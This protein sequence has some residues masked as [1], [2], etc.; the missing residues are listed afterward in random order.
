VCVSPNV[1]FWANWALSVTLGTNVKPV[2]VNQLGHSYVLHSITAHPTS[3]SGLQFQITQTL[4]GRGRG[5]GARE[6]S[7]N[8]KHVLSLLWEPVDA[9]R[10]VSKHSLQEPVSEHSVCITALTCEQIYFILLISSN[11]GARWRGG[12]LKFHPLTAWELTPTQV[13]F[14]TAFAS[15]TRK[16]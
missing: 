5:G 7:R 11:T 15:V 13:P 14:D 6:D 12:V 9:L 4:L 2:K 1:R 16:R 10:C 3:T 8:S